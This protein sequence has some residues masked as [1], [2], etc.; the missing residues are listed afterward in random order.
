M[1]TDRRGRDGSADDFDVEIPH[2]P[3]LTPAMERS[4]FR[5]DRRALEAA[6]VGRRVR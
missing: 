4:L 6:V 5:V 3:I 2:T 1:T